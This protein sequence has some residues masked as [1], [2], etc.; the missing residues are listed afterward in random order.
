MSDKISQSKDAARK[1]M[2]AQTEQDK[3]AFI[4]Q[5]KRGLGEQMVEEL[6][7]LKPPSRRQRFWNKLKLVFGL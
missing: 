6:E 1:M 7:K 4:R 3:Q 5:I 2:L